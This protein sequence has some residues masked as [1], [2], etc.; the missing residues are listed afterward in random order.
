M[1]TPSIRI[2]R[3]P[4]EEPY[5]LRFKANVADLNR[6]GRLFAGFY[7]LDHRVLEWR[8]QDGRLIEEH[9]KAV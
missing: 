4:Y 1:K 3:F 2:E 9:E 5:H 8:V 7:H 6:L